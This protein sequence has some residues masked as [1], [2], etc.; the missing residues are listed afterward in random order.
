MARPATGQVVER[1]TR[2]G[3]VFALRFRAYGNRQYVTL[4]ASEDGWT[5]QRAEEELQNVLADV[6]RGVWRP[7]TP[8]AAAAPPVDPTFHEFAS[9]WFTAREGEWRQSTRS[10]Y[11]WRLSQHLLPFFAEHRLSQITVAEVD[12]YREAKVRA[13]HLGAESIN[14]TLVLLGQVLDVAEERDLIARNPMRV[15]R[16]RRK[17][18]VTR[19]R[20]VYLDSAA[21]VAGLLEAASDLDGGPRARHV[22][23]RPLVATL[24][25]AGLRATEA[26][27]L[28][29]RDV[30]LAGGRIIV[31]RAKTD[32]G[33]REV[34]LLPALRDEL[35]A[36][37]A[38]AQRIGPDH[39]VFPNARGGRR[40]KDNLARRVIVPVVRRAEE[41][42]A[43]AGEQPLPAG[44]T[45][46]KLRHTFA[47]ILTALGRDPAYVM[48]QLGHTDPAF[49]LRVYAHAMRRGD[50]E[51]AQLRE[52]VEGRR[53][54]AEREPPSLVEARN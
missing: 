51:R 41:T 15:N 47:S 8:A 42:I 30:D 16:R 36:H 27:E 14:K 28:S 17:L 2:R 4:G 33:M 26:C 53:W 1:E 50:S 32:A 45:A 34:D 40:D 23:R 12:R 5:R 19:P 35:L 37:K 3:R 10:D 25:L 54:I 29:W 13:D 39:P 52:L 20:P 49:T 11:R 9:D 31:G 46:H 48:A 21:H 44:V 6:R 22:G 24:V 38:S 7:P 43:E 18:R